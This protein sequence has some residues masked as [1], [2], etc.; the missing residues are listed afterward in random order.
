MMAD[1]VIA[2]ATTLASLWDQI[3]ALLGLKS[4]WGVDSKAERPHRSV[5]IK[6]KHWSRTGMVRIAFDLAGSSDLQNEI[7]FRF[8]QLLAI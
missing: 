6:W 3:R 2:D 5:S 7:D 1:Y 8:T 4:A